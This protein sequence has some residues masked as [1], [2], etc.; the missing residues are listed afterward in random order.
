MCYNSPSRDVADQPYFI[1]IGLLISIRA[2]SWQAHL[3]DV[4]CWDF[5]EI[6]KRTTNGTPG[7]S[8]GYVEVYKKEHAVWNS[9]ETRWKDASWWIHRMSWAPCKVIRKPLGAYP[10]TVV[11]DA[12]HG[13]AR[14]RPLRLR[15]SEENPGIEHYR[16]EQQ[17][18]HG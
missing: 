11:G 3:F 7:C 17:R 14:D 18:L 8:G 2:A 16:V 10:F 4:R 1:P 6:H 13:W 15:L 5:Q 12:Q 9:F